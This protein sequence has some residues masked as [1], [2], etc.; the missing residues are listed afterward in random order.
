MEKVIKKYDIKIS[1]NN[2]F[3]FTNYIKIKY[4]KLKGKYFK[5]IIKKNFQL[6]HLDIY[7]N[8][9]V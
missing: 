9:M 7:F 5:Y 1:L 4:L 6:N 2:L 8:F 3:R